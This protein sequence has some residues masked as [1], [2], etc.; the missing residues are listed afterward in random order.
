MTV[1]DLIPAAGRPPFSSWKSVALSDPFGT[2]DLNAAAWTGDKFVAVG[3][4]GLIIVS[5]DGYV[6]SGA[7]SGGSSLRAVTCYNG[8][9][10][11][12]GDSGTIRTSSN[13]YTWTTRTSNT[14][15]ALYGVEWCGDRF[16]AVGASG[17][18]TSSSDGITWTSGTINASYTFR[19][20]ARSSGGTFLA[21]G[22]SGVAFTSA[23][24]T[25][26][27]QQTTG[28]SLTF[29]SVAWIESLSL[30]VASSAASPPVWT[31]PNGTS[32]S[33]PTNPRQFD[34]HYDVIWSGR[35]VVAVGPP[36]NT[37][38]YSSNG[39]TWLSASGYA[40][41][42]MF[43]GAADGFGTC[44]AVGAG[45]LIMTSSDYGLSWS[46]HPSD[47]SFYTNPPAYSP[48]L[49]LFAVGGTY[50]HIST[51][52]DGVSWTGR[53]TGG[54]GTV[55]SIAWG[56]GKFVALVSE[57]FC[58]TSLDGVSW[59]S[60]GVVFATTGMYSVAWS[61]NLNKFFAAGLFGYVY[62]SSDG[63]TWSISRS[64]GDTLNS[65][66]C[67]DSRI[68][69]V[70]AN[71]VVQTSAD[72]SAWTTLYPTSVTLNGVTWTGS[73]FVAVGAGGSVL[74][75]SDGLSWTC[76][77]ANGAS[78]VTFFGTANLF[79]KI[80]AKGT[81][82]TSADGS[83]WVSR[84]SN[85]TNDLNSM[86]RQAG[87]LVVVGNSGTILTSIN[88]V[89]WTSR[90][91]GTTSNLMQVKWIPELE[92]F[93]AVG[94][95]GTV[96]S[97]PDAIVWTATT[98]GSTATY[99]SINYDGTSLILMGSSQLKVAKSTDGGTTW[100]VSGDNT[101]NMTFASGLGLY[102]ARRESSLS[103]LTS[104]DGI[105]WT[106]RNTNSGASG[107][108]YVTRLAWGNGRLMAVDNAGGIST[109]VDGITFTYLGTTAGSGVTPTVLYNDGSQ[110]I[111]VSDFI[112]TSSDGITWTTRVAS[113]SSIVKTNAWSPNN[114]VYGSGIY[115]IAGYL[116][117]FR[118]TDLTN[119]T[120]VYT[121]TNL[122]VA[123]SATGYFILAGGL[124]TTKVVL[125]SIDGTN[126]TTQYSV[127]G[128]NPGK[129]VATNDASSVVV[130][131]SFGS[132]LQ[133]SDQGL[134][135]FERTYANPPLDTW[136]WIFFNGL[137]GGFRAFT[138][139]FIAIASPNGETWSNVWNTNYSGAVVTVSTYNST[140]GTYLR[141]DDGGSVFTSP[142]SVTWTQTATLASGM[143]DYILNASLY[144]AVGTGGKV[145]TSTDGITWVQ[146]TSGTT[147]DLTDVTWTG[148]VFI[149]VGSANEA[150]TS[151][152]GITWTSLKKSSG[153]TSNLYGVVYAGNSYIFV[154]DT[155]TVRVSP[156][157]PTFSARSFGTSSQLRGVGYSSQK[158][159][160]VVN[161]LSN[162]LRI[163]KS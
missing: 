147:A 56:A 2:T 130:A 80:G 31:S 108:T 136:Y 45:G 22:S 61:S 3:N 36:S 51:S 79:V 5:S 111:W 38:T 28:T 54:S 129:C 115:I 99:T 73:L 145:Y 76:L 32:W 12:V 8:L 137:G 19:G 77:D 29:Y 139:N 122:E 123:Y 85:T 116:G 152:D 66:A 25:A 18:Y 26:W 104:P 100:T 92:E 106:I 1:R 10:V 42:S 160:V 127:G 151:P 113:V 138:R 63:T 4:S 135:W 41:N 97:S 90:T 95:N 87:L 93:F 133:S 48:E 150:I 43:G 144:V 102:V 131:G 120:E 64:G 91:S 49:G 11:A 86:V 84:V 158:G 74:Y 55:Y 132:I 46:L 44:V 34:T 117:V 125:R 161:G 82:R 59:S 141:I 39:T 17:V 153:T 119:W 159:V 53:P 148:S 157:L 155:G 142:D 70:G 81:I 110:F 78:A 98:T 96:L 52:P 149:A 40:P 140:T 105:Y 134:T 112:K 9:C 14:A 114:M 72:G 24:G 121:S 15:S 101:L 27:T 16:I 60:S 88:G 65:V 37:A 162:T 20:I 118:S 124:G 109:S 58:R 68:V 107:G 69:A 67:S 163:S 156:A 57:T 47:V 30:F 23:N 103:V 143:R 94:A 146:R 35:Y 13:G 7:V 62:S 154:G 75:S 89:T 21:M 83:L 50:G 71:G 6:W 128:T 126:W 33:A